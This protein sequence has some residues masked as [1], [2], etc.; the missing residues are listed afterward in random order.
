MEQIEEA[1]EWA[2]VVYLLSLTC[3]YPLNSIF[4]VFQEIFLFTNF[5]QRVCI[6]IS[7]AAPFTSGWNV[8]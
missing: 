1:S 7:C 5:Q 6:N 8:L 4:T 2:D 3:H